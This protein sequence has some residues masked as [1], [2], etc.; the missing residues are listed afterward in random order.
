VKKAAN[1]KKAR[2]QPNEKGLAKRQA[3]F[4][5]CEMRAGMF[6]RFPLRTIPR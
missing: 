1:R 5:Q 4:G 2:G 6:K 3:S